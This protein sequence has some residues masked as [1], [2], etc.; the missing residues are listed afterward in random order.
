MRKSESWTA[1]TLG[2]IAAAEM[3]SLFQPG[4]PQFNAV[5]NAIITACLDKVT[6]TSQAIAGTTAFFNVI[7]GQMALSSV[8]L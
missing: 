5:K 3:A 2:P 7:A 1:V 8:G 4:S 6:Q